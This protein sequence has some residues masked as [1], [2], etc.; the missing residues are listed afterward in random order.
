ML[1]E[2][3]A[4]A[5]TVMFEPGV[6]ISLAVGLTR[7]TLGPSSFVDEE[8]GT[9]VQGAPVPVPVELGEAL[10][11]ADA[12]ALAD[13]EAEAEALA[14][15]D[16][17]ALADALADAE[18]LGLGDPPVLLEQATP[19]RVNAVGVSIE[20]VRLK[21]A[22]MPVEAPVA[23]EPFQLRLATVTVFPVWL[24]VPFQPLWSVSP[25]A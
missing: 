23:R 20:P 24:Q 25:P 6:K 7:E 13:A 15:A 11:E 2:E 9:T 5:W 21:L 4:A 22:P 18:A 19:L 12:L 1:P 16:A 8:P 3:H 17:E 14:D 10:A